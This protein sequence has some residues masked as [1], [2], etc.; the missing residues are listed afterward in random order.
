MRAVYIPRASRLEAV[1]AHRNA[2]RYV[3]WSGLSLIPQRT[4]ESKHSRQSSLYTFCLC[5][6]TSDGASAATCGHSVM[7]LAR[8]FMYCREDVNKVT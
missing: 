5:G 8:R 3:L 1:Q 4:G 7:A 6:G 2:A